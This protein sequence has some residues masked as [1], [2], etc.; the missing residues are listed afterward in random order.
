MGGHG[1]KKP[2]PE[3]GAGMRWLAAIKS[4]LDQQV[5]TLGDLGGE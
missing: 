3:L 1:Y 2:R 4:S 5:M